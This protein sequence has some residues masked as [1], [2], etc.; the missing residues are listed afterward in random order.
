M[1]IRF[2]DH[3]FYINSDTE[4]FDNNEQS[5]YNRNMKRTVKRVILVWALFTTMWWGFFPNT[6]F[7]QKWLLTPTVHAQSA[8]DSIKSKIVSVVSSADGKVT[9]ATKNRLIEVI[10]SKIKTSTNDIITDIYIFFLKEVKKMRTSDEILS[11]SN[12]YPTNNYEPTHQ[13][14]TSGPDFFVPFATIAGSVSLDQKFATLSIK[15]QNQGLAY[16]PDSMGSLKFGCKGVDGQLY[17]YRSYTDNQTISTNWEIITEIPNVY[18]G[19][20]TTNK[21][22]KLLTCKIDS[23]NLIAESN[24]DNNSVNVSIQIY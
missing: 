6:I 20:L 13:V 11:I 15:I 10:T 2:D 1:M 12:N 21:G 7:N 24:E 19:N 22:F 14:A 4:I 5:D 23:S 3:F 9:L 16:A 8:V 18:I 17:P